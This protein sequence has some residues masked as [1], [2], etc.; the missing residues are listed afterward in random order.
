MKSRLKVY[1]SVSNL[2]Q[3]R[4]FVR[5]NLRSMEVN[6]RTMEQVVLA[7]DEACANA[8]IHQHQCDGCSHIEITLYRNED[9][10]FVELKD[11]GKAFPID[12]YEPQSNEERINSHS[13]GG[14]GVLLIRSIMDSI[15]I[16]QRQD[17]YIFKFIKNL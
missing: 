8:I 4:D 2:S 14:M 12:A 13:K 16:D 7:V 10:L 11:V 15:Q 17:Y 3:I 9:Q 6:S 5:S 1:C